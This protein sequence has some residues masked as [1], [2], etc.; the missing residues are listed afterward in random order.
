MLR[1]QLHVNANRRSTLFFLTWLSLGV[2]VAAL[3]ATADPL[4]AW[5]RALG[6]LFGLFIPWL[7][8]TATLRMHR[9][10][11]D[12][13]EPT[14]LAA[15]HG[16]NRR[17]GFVGAMA[18]TVVQAMLVTCGGLLLCR[19]VCH[20]RGEAI[21]T[22]DLLVC[23]GIGWLATGAYTAYLLAATRLGFGRAGA[24]AAFAL[25]LTLGHIHAGWSL[26]LP[27]RHVL[28]LIGHPGV[29]SLSARASSLVLLGFLLVGLTF[30][31]AKTPR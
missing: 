21:W 13:L 3:E 28:N 12:P 11:A 20:G 4:A 23:C 25:D 6:V 7:A 18:V 8:L 16:A 17:H 30:A 29:F 31:T 2:L 24:W 1:A 27:H 10:L 14:A 26:A 19:V 22:S 15:R 9:T 5:E